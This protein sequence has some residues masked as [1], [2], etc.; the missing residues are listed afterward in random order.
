MDWKLFTTTFVTILFAEMGDKTQFAALGLSAAN[1]STLS[2]WLGVVLGLA[3]AGTIGILAGKLLG[4]TLPPVALK[5]I[6]GSLFIFMGAW[7]L[8]RG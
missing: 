5:W 3:V 4:N 2:V 1:S 6:S 8:I 7:T